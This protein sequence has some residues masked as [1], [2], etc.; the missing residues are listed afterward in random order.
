MQQREGRDP[1]LGR[2]Q[3]SLARPLPTPLPEEQLWS[4]PTQQWCLLH[5]YFE[6]TV[7]DKEDHRSCPISGR[8]PPTLWDKVRRGFW[9]QHPHQHQHRHEK[10]LDTKPTSWLS[11]NLWTP[12]S[13]SSDRH[14][15]RASGDSLQ[16]I[17]HQDLNSWRRLL[18]Y[19][20]K[21]SLLA[22]L[23]ILH[24]AILFVLD[25]ASAY[26][27]WIHSPSTR[28]L[29]SNPNP[30][31]V[32]S[33]SCLLY[34]NTAWESALLAIALWGFIRATFAFHSWVGYRLQG[35]YY[36]RHLT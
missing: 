14:H 33:L 16:T 25:E 26:M 36:F 2:A 5:F 35:R 28:S 19:S 30:S 12:S 20:D 18:K 32:N 1:D 8:K 6:G 24:H 10:S 9:H 22:S 29:H 11:R 21:N 7:K 17:P 3:K 15:T 34:G 4:L 13:S 27:P 31:P 23:I